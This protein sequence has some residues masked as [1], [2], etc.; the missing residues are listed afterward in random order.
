MAK[1]RPTDAQVDKA[2]A[3]LERRP[4]RVA[5]ARGRRSKAF[6]KAE[7]EAVYTLGRVAYRFDQVAAR[8][9]L[10]P[11]EL[12]E[13][14]G[15]DPSI[16]HAYEAGQADLWHSLLMGQVDIALD[17][18]AKPADRT[19]AFNAVAD[20]LGERG[21]KGGTNVSVSVVNELKVAAAMDGRKF[22]ALVTKYNEGRPGGQVIEGEA[23]RAG[24]PDK[25]DPDY[26]PVLAALG[27]PQVKVRD[28]D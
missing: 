10:S 28:R 13:A 21:G 11:Q 8:A 14:I 24:I 12:R 7:V 1:R 9:G 17:A 27:K 25:R 6:I 16:G 2:L 4:T 3:T 18:Q 23:T 22:R 19:R 5:A 15:L 26:N 20:S